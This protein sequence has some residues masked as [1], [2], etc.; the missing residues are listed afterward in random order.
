MI[1]WLDSISS[2]GLLL[3]VIFTREALPDALGGS[4]A[5]IVLF[6]F[7]MMYGYMA[8]MRREASLLNLLVLLLVGLNLVHYLSGRGVLPK[9][10]LLAAYN[11]LIVA[12]VLLTLS[13]ITRPVVSF[14]NAR[15][16]EKLR[17]LRQNFLWT[18]M[19]YPVF[20]FAQNLFFT[21]AFNVV[22]DKRPSWQV[23]LPLVPTCFAVVPAYLA[24]LLFSIRR[25]TTLDFVIKKEAE[26]PPQDYRKVRAPYVAVAALVGVLGT[27]IELFGRRELLL[28]GET[29]FTI[30]A[31]AWLVWTIRAHRY[32]KVDYSK[33]PTEGSLVTPGLLAIDVVAFVFLSSFLSFALLG[34]LG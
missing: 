26:E 22:Y 30:N 8:H 27:V 23:S 24:L 25:A 11:G 10:L 2:T 17:V 7:L 13:V 5:L 14:E 18:V 32:G 31:M 12:I 20:G 4:I 15:N 33:A 9:E 16:D 28:W 21:L 34:H 3:A 1:K 6:P 19:R 29:F